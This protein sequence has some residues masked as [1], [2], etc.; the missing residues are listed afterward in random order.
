MG[1]TAEQNAKP[2]ENSPFSWKALRMHFQNADRGITGLVGFAQKNPTPTLLHA[3]GFLVE[4]QPNAGGIR[5]FI[6]KN[7]IQGRRRDSRGSPI[8]RDVTGHFALSKLATPQAYAFLTADNAAYMR[9]GLTRLMY[10]T[11][12]DIC[13]LRLTSAEICRV[14]QDLLAEHPGRLVVRRAVLKNKRQESTVSYVRM[15]FDDLYAQADNDNAH[16]H[17]LAFTLSEKSRNRVILKAGLSR[18]GRLFYSAGDFS[19]FFNK[20]MERAATVAAEKKQ[21][22]TDRARSKETGEVRPLR[23]TFD[24]NIFSQK[25]VILQFLNVLNQIRHGET[26]IFHRNPYLHVSFFDFFDKSEFDVFVDSDNTVVIVPQY[27]A[28]FSSLFR[29][30]QKIFEN[31]QEGVISHDDQIVQLASA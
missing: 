14:I 31:F 17:S 11:R 30:C 18:D 2:L 26:T 20:V 28:S 25:T 5:P 12:V 6:S 27:E 22:L 9:D 1:A 8:Y 21:L 19:I 3:R 29:F 15:S 4:E 16:V 23:I 10:R 7:K 24:E 13:R